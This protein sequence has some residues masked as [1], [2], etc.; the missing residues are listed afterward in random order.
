[1]R[2]GSSPAA[3]NSQS[4]ISSEIRISCECKMNKN[5]IE[6]SASVIDN[7]QESQL[8]QE[9]L[10]KENSNMYRIIGII[11]GHYIVQTHKGLKKVKVV[12]LDKKSINDDIKIEK[13]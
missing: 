7:V 12:G 13:L 2:K 3:A 9:E 8:E 6:T 1:M 10:E 5:N 11:D 4:A